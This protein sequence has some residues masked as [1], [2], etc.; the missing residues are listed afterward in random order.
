MKTSDEVFEDAIFLKEPRNESHFCGRN[1]KHKFKV[2]IPERLPD[3]FV[4][5]FI[6]K[7]KFCKI[8]LKFPSLVAIAQDLFSAIEIECDSDVELRSSFY[9]VFRVEGTGT[10]RRMAD[11]RLESYEK[12]DAILGEDC[13]FVRLKIVAS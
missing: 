1:R 12:T 6:A 4:E 8:V 11:L 13:D 5:G 10:P 2:S 9:F 3:S 7:A